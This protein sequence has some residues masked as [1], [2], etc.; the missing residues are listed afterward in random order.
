VAFLTNQHEKWLFAGDLIITNIS[1]VLAESQ[2]AEFAKKT[3][4]DFSNVNEV[5]TSTI[6]FLF[7][8]QRRANKEGVELKLTKPPENLLSLLSLYG[9]ENFISIA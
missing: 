2:V 5:D 1:Q 3:I 6:S 8:L 9:V 4:L 7:E